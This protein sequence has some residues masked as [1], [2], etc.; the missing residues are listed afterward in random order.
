MPMHPESIALLNK[1]VAN[2]QGAYELFKGGKM[3]Q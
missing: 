1:A 2:Y 3:K